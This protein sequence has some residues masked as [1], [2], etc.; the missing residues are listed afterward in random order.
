LD[1]LF[2]KSLRT[3]IK[4]AIIGIPPMNAN[5]A[6]IAALIQIEELVDEATQN[7][8]Q[9]IKIGDTKQ[10]NASIIRNA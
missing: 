5:G 2:L 1:F 8:A 3:T 9:I 6:I 7:P 10:D 4:N